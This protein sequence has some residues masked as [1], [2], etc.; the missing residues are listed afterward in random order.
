MSLAARPGRGGGEKWIGGA[1]GSLKPSDGYR[2]THF[3]THSHM[4]LF[5][6][7]IALPSPRR[8]PQH[9]IAHVM[10]CS[11]WDYLCAGT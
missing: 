11:E 4:R 3:N 6:L 2:S 5:F 7:A 8:P 10:S 9:L 1:F